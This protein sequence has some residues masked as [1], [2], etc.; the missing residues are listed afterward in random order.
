M[1][2]AIFAT[3]TDATAAMAAVNIT[4]GYPRC[5]HDADGNPINPDQPGSFGWSMTACS[6]VVHPAD[7]RVAV[8]VGDGDAYALA[9]CTPDALL[10][11]VPSDFTPPDDGGGAPGM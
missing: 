2:V 6:V 11:A 5:G 4:L 1:R 10:D 8:L 7:G 9:A 3:A